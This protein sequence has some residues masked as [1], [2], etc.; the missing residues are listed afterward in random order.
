[1]RIIL[2]VSFFIVQKTIESTFFLIDKVKLTDMKNITII[3]DSFIGLELCGWLT[4]VLTDKK[5]V[6]V[7]MRSK[8]PMSRKKKISL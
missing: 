5:N 6:S 4:T 7:I 1:M 2:L 3:G 8:I